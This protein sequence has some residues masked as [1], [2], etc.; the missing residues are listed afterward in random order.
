M[1]S[2]DLTPEQKAAIIT[3][4]LQQFAAEKFQH[5][6]NKVTAEAIG[7]AT[8]AASSTAAIAQL[9]T[10]IGVHEAE[11]AIVAPVVEE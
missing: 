10:A 9:D 1:P 6:L 4:R 8:A 7:D 11:L 3:Q 5:E 2:Y